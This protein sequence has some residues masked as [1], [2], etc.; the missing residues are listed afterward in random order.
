MADKPHTIAD[1][2]TQNADRGP[3]TY[4]EELDRSMG[5]AARQR[6]LQF[7]RGLDIQ[8]GGIRSDISLMSE[9]EKAIRST[10]D[11]S[12]SVGPPDNSVRPVTPARIYE[13]VR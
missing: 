3:L 2:I 6:E 8:S 9:F 5:E 13:V 4:R 1:F 7:Q 10:P 12:P 11:S